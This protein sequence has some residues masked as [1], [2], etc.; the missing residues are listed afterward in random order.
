[1]ETTEQGS[2]TW[3]LLHWPAPFLGTHQFFMGGNHMPLLPNRPSVQLLEMWFWRLKQGFNGCY[4]QVLVL[5][6]LAPLS[7]WVFEKYSSFPWA[8]DSFLYVTPPHTVILWLAPLPIAAFLCLGLPSF[9]RILYVPR[10]S[11][12]LGIPVTESRRTRNPGVTSQFHWV[13]SYPQTLPFLVITLKYP[14]ISRGRV[15][16]PAYR[17]KNERNYLHEWK[18]FPF[19]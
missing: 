1:M 16:I 2:S 8:W 10:G 12:T 4:H 5:F 15:G 17:E 19:P 6:S 18:K 11:S 3:A 9:V 7:Q 13:L 14:G